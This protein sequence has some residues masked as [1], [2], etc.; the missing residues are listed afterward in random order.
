MLKSICV[1][2]MV[3]AMF[4]CSTTRKDVSEG[5]KVGGAASMV[6]NPIG[7]VVYMTGV[8]IGIGADSNSSN[9]KP[10]VSRAEWG[11]E[12]GCM[13][14]AELVEK[15]K[16]EQISST[17]P[18]HLSILVRDACYQA[19]T[20]K[21]NLPPEKIKV[22]KRQ[23]RSVPYKWVSIPIKSNDG[24]ITLDLSCKKDNEDCTL[25]ETGVQSNSWVEYETYISE[26]G[27]VRTAKEA[28]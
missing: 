10:H 25:R 17:T 11:E 27:K 9:E 21:F 19:V 3:S 1:C 20:K 2:I 6:N 18:T 14:S 28:L 8:L 13:I 16:T 12:H 15:V 23:Y 5:M 4:G 22:I 7:G 24:K 26:I